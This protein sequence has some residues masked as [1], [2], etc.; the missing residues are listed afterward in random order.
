MLPHV[1]EF[2]T[3]HNLNSLNDLV[4][5]LG[6]EMGGDENPMAEWRDQAA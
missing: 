5:V 3:V 6:A 1:D 4:K 2:R